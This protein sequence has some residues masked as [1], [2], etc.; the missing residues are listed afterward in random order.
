M[1][2][3]NEAFVKKFNLGRDAVGKR[4]R[5]GRGTELDIEIVGVSAN[6]TYNSVKDDA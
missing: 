5:R 6:T 4:I 2:V 1:A 3:V